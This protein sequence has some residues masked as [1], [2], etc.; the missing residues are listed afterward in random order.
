MPIPPSQWLSCRQ[1]SIERGSSSIRGT[2]VAPVA[3]KPESASKYASRGRESCGTEP[4]T[5]GSAPNTG[6]SNQI[7]A[8]TRKPSRGPT[9]APRFS[10]VIWS[11]SRPVAAV[12]APATRNGHTGSP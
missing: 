2:I 9:A 6:T 12:T 5:K 1:K 7:K 8:T 3:V 10:P 11:S 4:I